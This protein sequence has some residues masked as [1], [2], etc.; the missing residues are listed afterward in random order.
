MHTFSKFFAVTGACFLLGACAQV[1]RETA[2]GPAD[3]DSH[4]RSSGAPG[5]DAYAAC[6]KNRDA[7]REQ[8][9]GRR[10]RTHRRVADDMLNSR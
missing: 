7:A 9:Q 8:S 3:D 4:C 5:T 10:D 1:S 2:S 6:L